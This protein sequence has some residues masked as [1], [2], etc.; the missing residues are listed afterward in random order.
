[1]VRHQHYL[2]VLGF[3]ALLQQIVVHR[4][5]KAGDGVDL[6]LGEHRL[7]HG[8]AHV[9]DLDLGFVDAVFLHERL[10]LGEGAI[11]RRRAEHPTFEVLRFGDTGLGSGADRECRFVIDHQHGLDFL[12][13]VLVPEL[14]QRIDVEE[15]DRIGAGGDA[16]DAGNG[17]GA[18]IDGH[19]E[20]L[21]LVVPFIDRDE[22]GGRGALELPVEGKLHIGLRANGA[23][24]QGDR[25]RAR[26]HAEK[27]DFVH[28][29]GSL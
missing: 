13:R 2:D 23:H 12:V 26:E 22:V 21:G 3:E 9:L 10:P 27:P 24:R 17:A 15:A 8:K 14:D 25:R 18:G 6:A 29:R 5:R 20:T 11:G 4:E 19:V 28:V 16:G 7:A 1:M